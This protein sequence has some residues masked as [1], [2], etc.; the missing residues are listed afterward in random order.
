MALEVYSRQPR[1][2]KRYTRLSTA[3]VMSSAV[4]AELSSFR[5]RK[6]QDNEDKV[7]MVETFVECGPNDL[8]LTWQSFNRLQRI[9]SLQI[10]LRRASDDI[11]GYMGIT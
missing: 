3:A 6:Y 7:N 5:L 8:R 4:L 1:L 11:H 9:I 10:V 2:C